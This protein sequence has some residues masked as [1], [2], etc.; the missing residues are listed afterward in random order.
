MSEWEAEWR[1]VYAERLG[2]M[3]GDGVP[4]REQIMAAKQWADEHVEKLKNGRS[5]DQ[6]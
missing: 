3:V 6:N 4:T 1:Y 5:N 2:L